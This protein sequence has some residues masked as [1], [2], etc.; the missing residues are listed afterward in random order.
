MVHLVLEVVHPGNGAAP[1]IVHAKPAL[2][3]VPPVLL[4]PQLVLHVMEQLSWMELHVLH[5]VP[6]D[7]GA[8][9]LIELARLALRH[10]SLVP[11][12]PQHA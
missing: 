4:V 5:L 7:N 11:R 2:L 9:L 8:E 1:V 3:L 10:V 6:L 12:V